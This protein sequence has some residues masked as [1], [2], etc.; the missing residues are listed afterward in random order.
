MAHS[1]ISYDQYEEHQ[2]IPQT[3]GHVLTYTSK[4]T[5]RSSQGGNF[6]HKAKM[7]F[8]RALSKT[9]SIPSYLLRLY[10]IPN[11][12]LSP[13]DQAMSKIMGGDSGRAACDRDV[14]NRESDSGT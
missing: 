7:E 9:H 14:L 8:P 13:G 5:Q 2:E 11:T 1:Q 6:K 4:A 3:R 10:Y 12:I